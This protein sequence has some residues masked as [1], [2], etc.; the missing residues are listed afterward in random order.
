[1]KSNKAHPTKESSRKPLTRRE[2]LKLGMAA[3]GSLALPI[4][5]SCIPTEDITIPDLTPSPVSNQFP[6]PK[7]IRSSWVEAEQE[8]VLQ[9]TLLIKMQQHPAFVATPTP[10]PSD[11]GPTLTPPPSIQLRMYGSPKNGIT[12]NPNHD[13]QWD[14]SFPG[15][16]LRVKPGDRIRL[17]LLNYLEP[18][19]DD[20]IGVCEPTNYPTP[21]PTSSTTPTPA[22]NHDQFPNCFH[23]N[24][25]TNLHYH[26]MHIQPGEKGD[27]VLLNIY[28]HDQD[29]ASIPHEE[30]PIFGE[31][32]YDFVIPEDHPQGTFWYHP[33]RHGATD[34]QIANGMAGALIV[35]D[36]DALFADPQPVEQVLIIQSILPDVVF[37]G[38][39]GP[40]LTVNGAVK[41]TIYLKPGEVQRWRIINAT[42]NFLTALQLGKATEQVPE[43]L[44]LAV[45]G[46]YLDENHWNP[47]KPTQALFLGPGNRADVLAVA[48]MGGQFELHSISTTDNQ[49]KKN[50]TP[51]PPPH[52][53]MPL[54]TDPLLLVK[55]EGTPITSHPVLPAKLPVSVPPFRDGEVDVRC[56]TIVFGLRAGTPTGAGTGN[57]PQWTINDNQFDHDRVDQYMVKGTSETWTLIN[58]TEVAHPFHIHI[59]PFL[60]QEYSDPTPNDPI[61]P[62]T[63]GENPE[64]QWQDTIVIPNAVLDENGK[65][66]QPGKVV[67]RHRFEDFV[68]KFVLHCHILGHEDRGMMQLLQVVESEAEYTATEGVGP[69]SVSTP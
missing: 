20:E 30:H 29:P 43:M 27:D 9:T 2:L 23:E 39:G 44:L 33:H 53:N 1:M 11:S 25:V 34:L 49:K 62:I 28:P 51:T 18:L 40:I 59:N 46:N 24:N 64:K 14:W 6:Q 57:A 38:G 8:Y 13:N 4:L 67:I 52:P 69:C 26:G 12:A 68:G 10:P 48:G 54:S 42:G 58:N 37:P 56:R 63:T 65:V 47:R 35:E 15:P 5:A 60:I 3:A 17:K 66:I 61:K 21:G 55:V 19:A 32:D 41:P 36:K 7:T 31:H 45:D 22:L 50:M 16:T